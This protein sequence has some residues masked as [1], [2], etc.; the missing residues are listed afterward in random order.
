MRAQLYIGDLDKRTKLQQQKVELYSGQA[1]EYKKQLE[2]SELERGKQAEQMANLNELV[3]KLQDAAE[4]ARA[5]GKKEMDKEM[6][7]EMEKEKKKAFEE[8]Y[9]QGYVKAEDDMVDQLEAAEANFK[10]QQHSESYVL[11]YNK[12]LDNIGVDYAKRTS[13]EVPPLAGPEPSVADQ[14]K[15][16]NY[17]TNADATPDSLTADPTTTSTTS[18]EA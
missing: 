3:Q 11:R 16:A 15:G 8:G 14:A 17:E 13:I 18:L 9:A 1:N 7:K 12:A 10:A 2:E 6:E 5:E 4:Q